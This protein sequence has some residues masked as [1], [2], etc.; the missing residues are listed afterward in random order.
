MNFIKELFKSDGAVSS[1]RVTLIAGVIMI[2]F[3]VYL[4]GFIVFHTPCYVDFCNYQKGQILDVTKEQQE[5]FKEYADPWTEKE[6][7]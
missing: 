5:K 1:I 7:D 6:K 2:A 3:L 4:T